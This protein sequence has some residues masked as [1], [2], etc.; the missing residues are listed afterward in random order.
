VVFGAFSGTASTLAQKLHVHY[1]MG[2]VL[3]FEHAPQ[4]TIWRQSVKKTITNKLVGGMI[5]VCALG[6]VPSA[7]A[8]AKIEIDDVRSVS[9]GAGLRTTFNSVEDG[10]PSGSD[11]SSNFA[12]ESMRLYLSGNVTEK[13]SLVFNTECL[14]CGESNSKF[15]VLDAFA[16][17]AFNDGFNLHIGRHLTPADRIEM[18]G[19]Y[20]G[21]NWNQYT[22]P[23]LPSDQNPF[24]AT[25]GRYGRDD[26]ATIWGSFDK[27]QYAVGIFNGNEGVSNAEDSLLY[28][29]RFAYNF[30]NKEANPAYYTSSTYF[31]GADDILTLAF[32]IQSQSDGVGTATEATSFTAYGVDFLFEKI[33]DSANVL[34][35]EGELKK[36]DVDLTETMI[37]DPRCFCMFDGQT[38]FATAALLFPNK[39]GWGQLQPYFRYTK[40][41]PDAFYS[42]SD[43]TELGL[44][45]VIAGHNARL[46]LSYRDGDANLT[47]F[48]GN[49]VNALTFGVQLQL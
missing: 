22:I 7:L 28:S 13:V 34:T 11:R 25:A 17:F 49:D 46:N 24:D 15:F 5:T 35:L 1:W 12:V 18:N 2:D 20:Y 33:L 31:G 16:E 3:R 9:V 38:Y 48:P 14:A 8:G 41:E 30:L 47:G 32:F 39:V 10:A 44:N 37:A 29:G 42:S 19:P 26:G 21:L 40:N 6:L 23:L 36:H 43:L 27:F 45:Y 4:L